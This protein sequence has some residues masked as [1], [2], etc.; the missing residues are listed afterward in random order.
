MNETVE[1][2][3]AQVA[4][5]SYPQRT[6][7]VIVAPYE[8]PTV[9]MRRGREF[10]EIVSRGAFDG[11]Q[12][13][14]GSI[15]ANRD[16]DW[17]KLVGKAIRLYPER[18][19]GLVADVKIFNTQAGQETLELCAEDGLSAS[20]GFSL[21]C[22]NGNTGPVKPNAETWDSRRKVRRLNNVYLDHV[23]F[24]PDPAYQAAAVLDVRQAFELAETVA[25]AATPN[26]DRLEIDRWRA[27]LELLNSRYGV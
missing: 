17:G 23:A 15:R 22:E 11:V 20:A 13:R 26:L 1:I 25:A 19:E 21:M 8:T 3:Q 12:R 9:I 5:V 6:V 16:H 10:T 14:A 7:S 18:D 4:D 2:R 27:Q 24:V